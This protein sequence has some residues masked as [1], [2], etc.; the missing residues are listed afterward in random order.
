MGAAPRTGD[1]STGVLWSELERERMALSTCS[2]S[3]RV[4]G[5]ARERRGV[6]L[7]LETSVALVLRL[8]L[9]MGL[10]ARGV[11]SCPPAGPK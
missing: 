6:A 8:R 4:G 2:R 10:I 3:S 1:P 11:R 9:V 5:D 7:L